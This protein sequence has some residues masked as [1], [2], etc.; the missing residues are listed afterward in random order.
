MQACNRQRQ[1]DNGK[2]GRKGDSL[3]TATIVGDGFGSID[4]P[5]HSGEAHDAVL[6]C[7]L[8]LYRGID[9]GEH[10]TGLEIFQGGR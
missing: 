1:E 3:I 5:L 6:L 8:S 4:E 7:E 10:D 9:F 2:E